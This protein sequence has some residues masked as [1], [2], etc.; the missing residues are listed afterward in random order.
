[1]AYQCKIFDMQPY[2]FSREKGGGVGS[3]SAYNNIFTTK[4][5]PP[6]CSYSS[7]LSLNAAI[8]NNLSNIFNIT[9]NGINFSSAAT[10]LTTI[11]SI[12]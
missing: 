4:I 3:I 11:V 1:M 2:Q 12:L 6:T 7:Q 8:T 9:N 5:I 10:H